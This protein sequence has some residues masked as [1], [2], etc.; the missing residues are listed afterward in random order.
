MRGLENEDGLGDKE[1][2]SRVEKW[3][4]GEETELIQE[5]G[6]PDDGNEDDDSNLGNDAG[7]D[8]GIE[9][10]TL[11]LRLRGITGTAEKGLRFCRFAVGRRKP[12]RDG[13]RRGRDCCLLLFL[14]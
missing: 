4:S 5:H 10:E 12:V 8:E 13:S 2:A 3:M 11:A 14:A 1:D 7:S 9:L 6:S